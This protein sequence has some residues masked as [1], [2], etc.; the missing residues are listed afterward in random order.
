MMYSN[1]KTVM[2]AGGAGFLGSHLVERYLGDGW[3][4]IC[5][6]DLST[7]RLANVAM[8]TS[9]ANFVFVEHDIT[10]PIAIRADLIL[11]MACPASPPHYQR[12]PLKTLDVNILGTRNLLE[13]A[14]ATGARMLQS[15]TSEVYG[16]PEV[17][18]QPESYWGHVNPVGPR[19]CYDEGKRVAETLCMEHARQLGTDVRVAR[20]FNTYG[21]RMAPDD[22]RVVSNFVVQA[23]MNEPLTVYGDGTQTRS[24][25]Y[26]D[27]LVEGLVR[28]AGTQVDPGPTNLGSEFELTV[29]QLAEIVI[30]LVGAG[31]VGYRGLPGDDP[32]VRRPDASK[33]RRVLGWSADV[34]V[35][36]GLRRTVAYFRDEIGEVVRKAI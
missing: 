13:L 24:F 18:P 3:R 28:L 11:N 16:D 5:V 27:D 30:D 14:R 9:D 2:I 10:E 22:G 6:D 23:L 34:P 20:I 29:G 8:F 36:D 12:D 19:S 31:R 35:R 26:V 7:G 4:V 1:T 33:A 25:C 32:R 21:P 15:S 17:H